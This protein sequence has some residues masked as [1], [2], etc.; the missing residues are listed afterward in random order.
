MQLDGYLSTSLRGLYPPEQRA[1]ILPIEG[2]IEGFAVQSAAITPESAQIDVA[3]NS[4]GM[5]AIL[6]FNLI[7][8][9]G[10]WVIDSIFAEP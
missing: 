1:D 9:N 6:Q 5:D 3:L 10:N 7:R 4:G 8:E 2:M